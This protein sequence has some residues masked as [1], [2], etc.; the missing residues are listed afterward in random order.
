MFCVLLGPPLLCEVGGAVGAAAECIVVSVVVNDLTDGAGEEN[1]LSAP[2]PELTPQPTVVFVPSPDE[3]PCE[4]AASEC[5]TSVDIVA[6]IDLFPIVGGFPSSDDLT[7]C[8]LRSM[9]DVLIE[10]P[11]GTVEK[12]R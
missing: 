7:D 3:A 9:D 10:L 5:A 12:D 4:G 1:V 8:L 2:R 6:A 11:V